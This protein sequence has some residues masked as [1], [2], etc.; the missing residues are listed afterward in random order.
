MQQLLY[1]T[2]THTRA[3]THAHTHTHTHTHINTCCG[4]VFL[5]C[6]RISTKWNTNLNKTNKIKIYKLHTSGARERA[7]SLCTSS[8]PSVGV[9]NEPCGGIPG[10]R[11]PE[12]GTRPPGRSS[13]RHRER[14]REEA[15]RGGGA[16][17]CARTHVTER[18]QW[19]ACDCS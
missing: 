18:G 10:H 11:G 9:T 17:N 6:I 2:H 3:H 13:G 8:L 5:R 16:T 12:G 15:A 4:S 14:E 19:R 1:Y 7:G